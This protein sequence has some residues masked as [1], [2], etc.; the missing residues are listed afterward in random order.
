MFFK[1]RKGLNSGCR[2]SFDPNTAQII[3]GYNGDTEEWVYYPRYKNKMTRLYMKFPD[4]G[5]E[6]PYGLYFHKKT[7]AISFI[8]DYI[9][10][11]NDALPGQVVW[12]YPFKF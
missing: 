6:S 10:T 4:P 2:P 5:G 7:D 9:E 8:M 11:M 3:Y 12:N 1:K